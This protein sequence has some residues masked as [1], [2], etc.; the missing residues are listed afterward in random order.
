[1]AR[2][3][4]RISFGL[5]LLC[6]ALAAC[7]EEGDDDSDRVIPPP[8]GCSNQSF[9]NVAFDFN[10]HFAGTDYPQDELVL[11]LQAE[12]ITFFPFAFPGVVTEFGPDPDDASYRAITIEATAPEGEPPPEDPD[13]VRIRYVLP[14]GYEMPVTLGQEV[15]SE[16]VLDSTTGV[17][18]RAFRVHESEEDGAALLF[19]TEPS[20]TGLVYAPGEDHPVFATVAARDRACPNLRTQPCGS[21]YNLS[22]Q[23]VAH[24]PTE[25]EPGAAMELWPAESADFT[26][27]GFDFQVVSVW[28][29]A[30]REID[31][32]CT[33]GFD[34][35]VDR[36]TYFVVR[37]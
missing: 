34:Y 33:N 3:D 28:S 30:F 5:A 2:P 20:E 13:F 17:L 19:L 4:P 32:D 36:F 18:H 6:L 7:A 26:A 27:G 10:I 14:P 9:Q 12:G 1:M 23:F 31:P 21:Q 8:E 35:D 29:Y 22:V 25:G 11:L 15:I 37:R 16:V 24:P